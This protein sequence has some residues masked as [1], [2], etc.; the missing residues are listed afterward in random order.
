MKMRDRIGSVTIELKYFLPV[1]LFLICDRMADCGEENTEDRFTCVVLFI[2][3][4]NSTG[5]DVPDQRLYS[6]YVLRGSRIL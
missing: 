1:V 4:W 6:D 2:S 5:Y 3:D